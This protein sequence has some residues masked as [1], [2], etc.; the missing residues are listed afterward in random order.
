MDNFPVVGMGASAGGL[1]AFE[2]FFTAMPGNS[3]LAFVLIAHLDP[4]HAS[5]L[6]ELVQKKTGMKVSQ[7]ADNMEISPNE[8][9]IIPPNRSLEIFNGTLQLFE[10]T[11]PRGVNMPID[12]FFRSLARDRGSEA[13]AIVLSGTGTDGTLGLRA[14]KGEAGVAMVQDPQTAKYDGMPRNAI[15]SGM[16]DFVLSPEKMAAKL[17]ELARIHKPLEIRRLV[18]DDKMTAALQK[19]YALLRAATDHDFSLYK[20]NTLFRR[21]ERRMKMQQIETIDDY[22]RY[23]QESDTE[24]N[25][26][27]K[28]LLIG[29]TGFFRDPLAFD[30]LK[31]HYLPELLKEKRGGSQL[32]VWVPGCST[33]EEAYSIAILLHEC[34]QELEHRFAVQ[35]FATD[36]DDEAIEFAR[37]G[38]YP[39]SIAADI[40][41]DR[42]KRHF[43]RDDNKY[44]ISKP[45]REMVIFATQNIIKDPPFT[46]LDLLCCRNL[47][48]YFGQ[49]LQGKLLPIFHYSLKTGGLLFLGTSETIGHGESSNRFAVL[50]RKWKI[51]KKLPAGGSGHPAFQFAMATGPGVEQTEKEAPK[52]PGNVKDAQMAKLLKTVLAQSDM[53]PFVIVDGSANIIYIHGRTGRYLEPAEGEIT[54]N[55]VEMARPGLRTALINAFRKM[56]ADRRRISLSGLRIEDG[57]GYCEVDLTIRPLPDIQTGNRG[58]MMIIFEEKRVMKENGIPSSAD[59]PE[60]SEEVKRI[61]EELQY[62][63]ENLQIT[64]EELETSNEELKSTNEELQSTNEELETSKEELQ[65]LNEESI[66]VNAELQSRIDELVAT[67]D[68]I[69]NLLDATDIATIFLDIDLNV[70]RFTP[71]ATEL[72]HLTA[73]D[74][75]R[76]IEHFATTLKDVR[77]TENARIVLKDLGQHESEASDDQG[78]RYRMRVRPYRTTNN[79]IAGVVITFEDVTNYKELVGALSESET[80]WRGFVENA[81]MGIFITTDGTFAYLNPRA[82]E[83]FGAGVQAEMLGMPIL[84]RIHTDHHT[85]ASAQMLITM[86]NPVTAVEETWLRLDGESMEMVI[87]AMPIS[88]QRKKGALYFVREKL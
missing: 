53:S 29:V 7:V 19:I 63:R 42:L 33:G 80:L 81:P 25:I 20:K 16:A 48:I 82:L 49:E 43:V 5:I 67:N 73:A 52:Q 14:I 10:I 74:I 58:L 71:K 70:R 68:D 28:E 11:K 41:P 87:S 18:D 21:I 36:L 84:D 31:E 22:V 44:A 88:F 86:E 85:M 40:T 39:E 64:I 26:L 38:R 6:P 78:R 77:L 83:L 46:K 8:V 65:S 47:L 30:A 59:R 61:E 1:Q 15:A 4:D 13:I 17:F 45:I 51:F 50:D 35:I 66:T 62:T 9:Y 34:M 76:P 27:F 54:T 3:G 37:A 23:L 24:L 2:E 56:A 60:K 79:V 75:G 55:I 72:F 57:G 69:K 12:S 32:R